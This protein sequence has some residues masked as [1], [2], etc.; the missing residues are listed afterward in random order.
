[1]LPPVEQEFIKFI[2]SPEGNDILEK[3]KFVPLFQE[4][5]AEELE[6]LKSE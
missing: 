1:M 2:F 5:H 6:K 3:Q 4:K